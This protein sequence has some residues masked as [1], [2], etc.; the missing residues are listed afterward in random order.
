MTVSGNKGLGVTPHSHHKPGLRELSSP[1]LSLI[2]PTSL[3]DAVGRHWVGKTP[4]WHLPQKRVENCQV[5][6][7]E[8]FL[9]YYYWQPLL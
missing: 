6:G 3:P 1:S 7:Q 8:L 2:P 5:W 9:L 4:G